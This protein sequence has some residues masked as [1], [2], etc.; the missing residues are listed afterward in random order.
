[1]GK[2]NPN[3]ISPANLLLSL[4]TAPVLVALV[5]GRT[6]TNFILEISRASEEVFRGDRL[7]IIDPPNST[8]SQK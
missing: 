3:T 7:P 6:V 8:N 4:A 5:G 1:M 2:L